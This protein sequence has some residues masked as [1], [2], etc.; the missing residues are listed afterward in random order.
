M[1]SFSKSIK[2]CLKEKYFCISGRASRAEYWW[3]QLFIV[4]IEALVGILLGVISAILSE[5][6]VLAPGIWLFV[7]LSLLLVIPNFCVTVRRL[8]DTGRSGFA[9]F[10]CLIPY[11]GSI[12]VFVFTLLG[13]SADNEY[14]PI[15]ED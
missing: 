7:I 9:L 1:V 4:I 3:F 13:S 12:I 10:F 5:D 2:T 15:P 11:V 8:H 6:D 14:G